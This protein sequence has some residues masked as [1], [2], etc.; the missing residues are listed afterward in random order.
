[1]QIKSYPSNSLT[2]VVIKI[3]NIK[4]HTSLAVFPEK[5]AIQ[6]AGAAQSENSISITC[7]ILIITL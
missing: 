2:A 1:M 6:L 5:I 3:I 7:I 4:L